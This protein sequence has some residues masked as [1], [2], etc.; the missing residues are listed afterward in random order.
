LKECEEQ[1]LEM[2]F[3]KILSQINIMPI[4]FVFGEIDSESAQEKF[5]KQ[6]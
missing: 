3:E 5:D 6:M 1:L 2:P 4:K